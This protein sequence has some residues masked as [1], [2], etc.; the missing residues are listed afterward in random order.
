MS[1]R[2]ILCLVEYYAL[3]WNIMSCRGI[4]CL[5]VEYYVLSWNIMGPNGGFGLQKLDAI[6]SLIGEFSVECVVCGNPLH[7]FRI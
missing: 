5:V 3:P 7:Q 4:L 6:P 1:C 2:G